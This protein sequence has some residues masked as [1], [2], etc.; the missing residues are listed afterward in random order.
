MK[1]SIM[2]CCADGVTTA[3]SGKISV[4][5][6]YLELHKIL[7]SLSFSAKRCDK[8]TKPRIKTMFCGVIRQ[9]LK[10]LAMSLL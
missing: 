2:Q 3:F 9:S 8:N 7:F 6:R 10:L 5:S 1:K 4:L